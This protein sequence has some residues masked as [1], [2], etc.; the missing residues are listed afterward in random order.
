MKT[1]RIRS[2]NIPRFMKHV[3]TIRALRA[4]KY[5]TSVPVLIIAAVLFVGVS[6]S[7][8]ALSLSSSLRTDI[9]AKIADILGDQ[10]VQKKTEATPAP[11]ASG[12]KQPNPDATAQP[13]ADATPVIKY[14]ISSDPRS[15]AY[16]LTPP[17]PN[18]ASFVIRVTHNG[19]LAAGQLL[20]YNATKGDKIY[21]GGDLVF[22]PS[23]IAIHIINGNPTQSDPFTATAPDGASIAPP[24][25]PWYDIAP[26][27]FPAYD[28]SS[29]SYISPPFAT[30]WPMRLVL[31]S[32]SLAPGTYQVHITSGK[33]TQT[34]DAWEYDGFIILVVDNIAPPPTHCDNPLVSCF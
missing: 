12:T 23:T 7:T 30:S 20:A 31:A 1:S 15:T 28:S 27:A 8:A 22:S 29:V 6:G 21:Y 11:T 3:S 26:V 19:Q 4:S 32:S 16:S 13:G 2:F 9:V 10:P 18:P 17:A 24:H 25:S 34:A 33:M 5:I 14:S